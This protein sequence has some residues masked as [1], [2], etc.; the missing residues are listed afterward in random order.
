MACKT[1]S[2]EIQGKQISVTQWGATKAVEMQVLLLSVMQGYAIDLFETTDE[3]KQNQILQMAMAQAQ[4]NT[5]LS[6]LK[7]FV[8]AAAVDGKALSETAFDL[9]YSGNLPRLFET[10]I[11][12]V[13]VNYTSFFEIGLSK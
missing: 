3:K 13:Q 8:M 11:F 7:K 4:P 5:F 6:M 12:V 1:E 10:F 2:K 9:E